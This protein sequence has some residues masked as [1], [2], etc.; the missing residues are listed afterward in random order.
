MRLIKCPRCELNYMNDTDKM[1]SVCRKEVRGESESFEMLEMC[2]ECG[3]NP[4]LPG[5]ELCSAC[6]KEQSA[7]RASM[8]SEDG[9]EPD[10]TTSIDLET[11]VSGMDEI[12]LDLHG[13]LDDEEF[14]DEGEFDD[15]DEENEDE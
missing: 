13:G 11:S 7:R 4:A 9:I 5:Q 12:E 6:L 8:S 1:C 10:T 14:D 2:S 15:E 3:E